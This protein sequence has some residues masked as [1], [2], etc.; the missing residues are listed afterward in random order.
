LEKKKV[1]GLGNNLKEVRR[2]IKMQGQG[3]ARPL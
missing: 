3:R 2:L 1:G